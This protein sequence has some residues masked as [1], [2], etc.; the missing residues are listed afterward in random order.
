MS[1]SEKVTNSES[2]MNPG[3]DMAITN[4]KNE[5][6]L[7]PP[8]RDL[9]EVENKISSIQAKVLKS[10]WELGELLMEVKNNPYRYGLPARH[11]KNGGGV[12]VAHGYWNEWLLKMNINPSSS[13]KMIKVVTTFSKDDERV[14]EKGLE[15]CY[16]I[17]TIEDLTG[18][19]YSD[20]DIYSFTVQQLR[21]TLKKIRSVNNSETIQNSINSPKSSNG[22][23]FEALEEL[24]L[25]QLTLKIEHLTLKERE[26]ALNRVEQVLASYFL[27]TTIEEE[28][29]IE[30]LISKAKTFIESKNETSIQNVI[31]SYSRAITSINGYQK[32]EL[33]KQKICL[34][35]I[36]LALKNK[37]MREFEIKKRE[38]M[39]LITSKV[40]TN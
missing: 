13:R 15:A 22:K 5:Q 16:L 32:I 29:R 11:I 27:K 30:E 38:F 23:S 33:I 21:E 31:D 12:T 37:E 28:K 39:N 40:N 1:Y 7:N 9:A 10:Y 20:S 25:N 24:D 14:K 26:I 4:T 36:E 35:K 3:G 8:N 2:N 18:T 19:K 17:A 34:E 6:L